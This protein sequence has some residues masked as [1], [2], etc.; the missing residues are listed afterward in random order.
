MSKIFS[1]L[2]TVIPL[3]I[4]LGLVWWTFK[5]ITEEDKQVLL[6]SFKNANYSWLFLSIVFSFFSHVFRA[7]RWKYMLEPLGLKPK[8]WASFYAVMIGYLINMLIPRMGEVS[9]SVYMS[10]ASNMPFNQLFGTIVAER[11]IDAIFLLTFII[12]VFF[13]QFDT[14]G[15]YIL[16]LPFFQQSFNFW[17]AGVILLVLGVGFYF[18]YKLY[19]SSSNALVAKIRKF[20]SGILEGLTTVLSM[21][22]KWAFIFYTFAIWIMYVLLFSVT[23]YSLDSV[24]EV[25]FGGIVSAFVVGGLT[26]ATT[27]GGVG[28]YPLGIMAI[29]T[30]YGINQ[31]VGLAFGWLVW[32]FQTGFIISLGLISLLLINFVKKD[33]K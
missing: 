29:L 15:N 23:F 22:D 2:K 4:G 30:L 18:A 19:L 9:R 10:K 21:K 33:E 31:N 13:I 16:G 8:F 17:K 5:D 6:D 12:S 11:V 20:I 14:I 25:P 27:N 7:Y 32:S 3:L 1:I 28:A 26:V 24:S